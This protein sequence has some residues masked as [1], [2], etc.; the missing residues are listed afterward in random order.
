MYS[1]LYVDDEEGL[2]EIAKLFLE[3]TGEFTV[4]TISSARGALDLLASRSFD[5]IIS[6]YQMPEIDGIGF[7]KTARSQ[8]GDIPF[9]LFTGRGREEIAIEAMNNGADFY[10]QKG[11][12]P[13]AQYA[14]L[15]HKLRIAVERKAARD[16]I[17]LNEIRLKALVT[18][19]QMAD[20]PLRNL[21]TFAIEEGV[22]ITSGTMGYLAFV[23]EDESVLSM[24]AW[25]SAAMNVCK[26]RVKPRE[27][28]VE[29]TGLW[30]EAI[31]QRRP[32]ITN[33]YAAANP[34][35]KG[36]PEGH[37]P[38]QRHMNIPVF[39]GNRIVMVAG[40]ANKPT[41]FLQSDARELALLMTGLWN[42]VK[43]RKT[44]DALRNSEQ[45]LAD[46]INFLP[47]ATFAIDNRGMVIAWNRAIEEMTGIPAADMLGKGNPDYSRAIYPE[48]RPL[49]IDLILEPEQRI[50]ELGY[51]AIH[52]EGN[53]LISES[54][55]PM[56][57]G[58]SGFF[59]GKASLLYD[60]DGNVAGA[61]ESIRD[62]TESK[63]AEEELQNLN[64]EITAREEEL[65]SQFDE[66]KQNRDEIHAANE[67]ITGQDEEL[68][69][70]LDE[71][72]RV[73]DALAKN[74][75]NFRSLVESAPDAIYISHREHFVYVNP[76]AVR[77]LGAGSADQLLG[78]SI[79]DRMHP[80]CHAAA[81]G[82]AHLIIDEQKPG[83]LRDMVYLK[84]DGTPVDVESSV[85][86]L[87]Y[88]GKP[89][90][91]VILRE[92]S[93]RKQAEDELR[94][95]HEQITATE[96]ELRSQYNALGLSQKSLEVSERNYRAILE[97]I[98]DVYYRTD[99][100]GT[101][102]MISPS[103]ATLLGHASPEE[104]V[105]KPATD[106]YAIPSQRDQLLALLEKDRSVSDIETALKRKDGTLVIVSTSSHLIFDSRGNVAGV[107]GI[108]RDITRR[109]HTESLLREEEELLRATIESAAS[110][111]LVV[112]KHQ[113]VTHYNR[114]FV[115]MWKIPEG[116]FQI[117]DDDKLLGFVTGQLS[118]PGQFIRKVR[119]LYDSEIFDRDTLGFKDGRVF[120]RSS[121]PLM[122]GGRVSGRV[123]N[124]YD[125]TE[126]KRTADELAESEERYRRLLEQFFDAVIIH[127]DNAIVYAND[128]AARLIKAG[129]PAEMIGKPVMD[130]VD[131]RCGRLVGERIQA[132]IS[133]P[134]KAVPLVE[135][136]F[137]CVDGTIVEVEVI[138]MSARFHGK[139]AVQVVAR[140]ITEKKRAEE[141][142]RQIDS[143]Y[144]LILKSAND[145]ILIH[146]IENNCPGMFIEANDQA[147]RM[148][149]YTRAELLRMSVAD[150][151]IPGQAGKIPNIQE[152][153]NATGGSVFQTDHMTK[154]RRRIPVEVS[155][156]LIG[157]DGKPAVLSLIRD[158]SELR[159]TEH[160]VVEANRKLKLLNS[161]TRHDIRNKLTVLEGYL[162][163]VKERSS[164]SSLADFIGK[165]ESASRSIGEHIEFTKTYQDLG[166][167]EPRWQELGYV[168]SCMR[169]PSPITL[170]AGG[171]GVAVYA[172]P[173]LEKVFSNLLDNTLRHGG[174]VT[175]VSVSASPLPEGLVVVWEDNGAG[176]PEK[177][178]DKIF[179]QGY[180][181]NTGL[182]LFLCREILSMTGISIRENGIPGNGARFEIVIP[183]GAYRFS[184]RP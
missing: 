130:F 3:R 69:Q 181:R 42:V 63:N 74:E 153:L 146:V 180:G 104:M 58:K 172:D 70:Q 136:R 115:E 138:A 160:A 129:S 53:A 73:R 34:L 39:D 91:L 90:G 77:L 95:A 59:L 169:V 78:M 52:K 149:G 163:L 135:E 88:E 134:G 49:L 47:D 150:I 40:V 127:Q 114:R 168:L 60:R 123:W 103:A 94:A 81:T 13:K 38:I 109:K 6:D 165:M 107:E 86:P 177:D 8:F 87:R 157:I 27:Y 128:A 15:V 96:E 117:R 75:E 28:P 105:G 56:P 159:R 16:S 155:A 97:N 84:M 173:L 125:I 41:D 92:I 21:M 23:N 5:A 158:L 152:Q 24:Y 44:E 113:M 55:A 176:I 120:E 61:I 51:T 36:I 89:A 46:I 48:P 147:C 98:Q 29:T 184:P 25:S 182:G 143:R 110:G 66:L 108:F 10:L 183:E 82:R 106:F 83:G 17:A 80:S 171:D 118:D 121:L 148:L 11:G 112:D 166:T 65:R 33:N 32:V 62:I 102:E 144:R 57:R 175:T 14:E 164:D 1:V 4:E 9:I 167:T 126:Q 43:R 30:G 154:D 2:L 7:L 45:R 54:S 162:S 20:A 19:Y 141:E 22:K 35:K 71:I 122:R 93:V 76:A 68:R 12:D 156:R 178:K 101:I 124:F 139:P 170:H 161:I 72:I 119:D 131:P 99:K 137:R 31:R 133:T 50:G 174:H 100:D 85:A 179:E 26:V 37:V 140:D 132:M 142:R 79:Y 111:I 64:E 145:A 116:F 67:Q 18:F 151:D